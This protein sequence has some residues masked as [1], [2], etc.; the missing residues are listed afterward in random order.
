MQKQSILFVYVN[1]SSFVKADFEIL[2]TFASVTKYQF[3]PG[4]GLINTGLKLLKQFSFLLVNIWRYDTVFIW[5]ADY[6]TLLPVII[7]KLLGKKSFVVIGGYEVGRIKN[8]NYGVLCSKLRGFFCITSIRLCTLNLTVSNY[9]DRK[10]KYIAPKSKRQL[11]HNCVDFVPLPY[12][13]TE[14]ENLILTVGLI[15]NQ[16]SFFLKGI[17]TFIEVARK[18]PDYQFI[19]IG[20]DNMKLSALLTNIPVNI[21]IFGRVAHEELPGYYIRSKFYCQLSRSESFGVSVAEAMF[22]GCIPIVTNEGGLPELV[23]ELGYIVS[24]NPYN[25][26]Q[27]ISENSLILPELQVAVSNRIL[28]GFSREKRKEKLVKVVSNSTNI[29]IIN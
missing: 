9:I 23:G 1:Y 24:R 3:K 10:I 29:K 5:F 15:E 7:A 14:K 13:G 6:H 26:S 21:T 8:L 20:L 22:Y 4:K 28:S 25:I 17:D 2:S 11:I 16:R 18:L 27:L 19:I 12:S